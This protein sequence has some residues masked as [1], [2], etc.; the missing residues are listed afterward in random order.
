M[1]RETVSL[2]TAFHHQCNSC[3][4]WGPWVSLKHTTKVAEAGTM[5]YRQGTCSATHS[6]E[7]PSRCDGPSMY[8]IEDYEDQQGSETEKCALKVSLTR[9]GRST[10]QLLWK[11]VVK[12]VTLAIWW[13]WPPTIVVIRHSL[14]EGNASG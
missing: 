4:L 8:I 2:S 1:Q 3:S 13:P 7:Q 10:R 11:Y 9:V 14:G 12:F 6:H 5:P